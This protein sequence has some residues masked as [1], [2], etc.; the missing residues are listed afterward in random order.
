[1]ENRVVA[2]RWLDAAF[3]MDESHEDLERWSTNGGEKASTVGY[4]YDQTEKYIIVAS[5]K[6]EDGSY[7]G[8]TI[9]PMGMITEIKTLNEQE[10]YA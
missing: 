9:I 4:V 6:F 5:E 10:P 1:M 8:L 2:V 7:R 3:I